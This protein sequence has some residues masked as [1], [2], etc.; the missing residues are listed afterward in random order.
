MQESRWSMLSRRRFGAGLVGLG[1]VVLG[2]AYTLDAWAQEERD[3]DLVVL[4]GRIATMVPA[5]PFARHMAVRDGLVLET[6][7][8]ARAIRRWIGPTTRVIEAGGRTVIP[9][10]HDS[11]IHLIR[12]GLN[13]NLELRWDGVASVADALAMLRDQAQRT[14]APQWV[15]VVGGWSEYQFAEKRLPTLE[16]INAATGDVPCMITLHYAAILLNHAAMRALGYDRN[17][18][19]PPGGRIERDVSGEPTGF[20]AAEPSP[21]IV[22]STIGRAPRLSYDDQINSTRWFMRDLNRLGLTSVGDAAGG[23]QSYPQDYQVIE[24]LHRRGELTVRIAYSLFAQRRGEELADY[25][26]WTETVEPGMGDAFYRLRGAGENLVWSAAD[27]ENFLLPRDDLGT[28]ME[29][30]LEAVIRLFAQRQW[31]FRLHGTY[32]ESITRFLDVFERVHRDT[33][34][35]RLGWALDHAETISERSLERLKALGGAIAV[36]H[37]MAFQGEYFV[38]RY[39][40]PHAEARPPIKRMLAMGIPVGGGSD[41]TRISSYNP[42]VSLYWMSTGRTVGGLEITSAANRLDRMQALR[43]MTEG[44]AYF[45]R[46]QD[47]KGRLAQGYYADF[48]ILDRDFFAISDDEIMGTQSLLTAVGG[49]IVFG[50]AAFAALD[51]PLPAVS[52]AWSPVARLDSVGSPGRA[53]GAPRSAVAVAACPVHGAARP[54]WARHSCGDPAC[55]G[56]GFACGAAAH[57]RRVVSTAGDWTIGCSCGA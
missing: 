49:K 13:F 34:I 38:R 7:D 30:D 22:Y 6:G 8:S 15:R 4:N 31:P 17:S 44:S 21:F 56:S 42:F 5:A 57:R 46:D 27:Y 39:G 1:A 51:A 26:R 19:N 2:G 24:D 47:R 3:A 23:G 28:V 32:E 54:V 37:R 33:P 41:A 40:R 36:Q 55:D 25:T 18:P 9:G 10:L 43:L 45:S 35:D 48:A 52:P 12:G 11:H 53:E 16:E 50:Q 29:A 20:F 14:P